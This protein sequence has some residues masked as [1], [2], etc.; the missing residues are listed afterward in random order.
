MATRR[1][2]RMLEQNHVGF[3]LSTHR[4]AFSAMRTAEEAHVKGAEMA[5]SVAL[6]VDGMPVLAV[7]PATMNVSFKRMKELMGAKRISLVDERMLDEYFPDCELGAMPAV[8]TMYKM[9]VVADRELEYDE[10]ISFN[11]GTHKEIVTMAFND[12][13]RLTHPRFADI[14]RS[15]MGELT[16]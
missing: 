10:R 11:A 15:S 8:G 14:H 2:M 13:K 16:I 12:W 6:M 1:L 9:P 4:V 7:L 5:K 3:R